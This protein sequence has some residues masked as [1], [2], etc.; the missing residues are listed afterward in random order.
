[1]YNPA[2]FALRIPVWLSL[3][4]SRFTAAAFLSTHVSAYEFK[5]DTVGC[6]RLLLDGE[7]HGVGR[8]T[9]GL[10]R[11]RNSPD[12]LTVDTPSASCL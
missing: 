6:Q 1:L 9:W 2:V 5:S 8:N 10:G 7:Q 3:F 4:F 11:Y 12:G